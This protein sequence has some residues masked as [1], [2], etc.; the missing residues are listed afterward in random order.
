MLAALKRR[1]VGGRSLRFRLAPREEG[2]LA[3]MLEG[4]AVWVCTECV[5]S[6]LHFFS[7][8]GALKPCEG[9]RPDGCVYRLKLPSSLAWLDEPAL[10]ARAED[11]LEKIGV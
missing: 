2:G 10:R 3:L 4:S 8:W 1:E 6:P 5:G 11:L 7:C 9:A